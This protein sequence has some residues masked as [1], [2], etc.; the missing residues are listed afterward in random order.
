MNVE[1]KE[2]FFK[3]IKDIPEKIKDQIIDAICLCYATLSVAWYAFVLS[4]FD[5]LY[6][7]LIFNYSITYDFNFNRWIYR[8]KVECFFEVANYMQKCFL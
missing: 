5:T 1:I 4:H 8:G 3:D 7:S 6:I 2:S